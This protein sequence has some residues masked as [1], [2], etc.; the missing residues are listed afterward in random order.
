MRIIVTHLT[1]MQPGH[2]CVAG[3][4]EASGRQVRPVLQGRLRTELLVT[5]GGFLDMA[6]LV[7]LGPV[8]PCG[9]P[10]EVEDHRFELRLAR[11]L[12]LVAAEAFWGALNATASTRLGTIFGPDLERAGSSC[13]VR[14]GG[15]IASLG[16][17]IPAA[18][19]S[20]RLNADGH[21]RLI[22]TDGT[23]TLSLPVTDLRLFE[24]DHV[25]PRRALVA[26]IA[27]RLAGPTP[28]V[29]CVGLTRPWQKPGESAPRHW[30]Q[31]NN[32]HL[33]DHLAWRLE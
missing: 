24:R 1:R 7:D 18:P 6:T 31:V 12:G 21:L 26:Q 20:L 33:R 23:L 10:P 22:V 13:A 17:L 9:H 2:C 15:G 19:P 3:V 5:Q 28:C 29:L 11:A 4:D 14:E 27:A 25:T 30:L 32:I 16:T 8:E